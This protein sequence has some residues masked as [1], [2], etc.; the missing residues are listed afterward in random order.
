[1]EVNAEIWHCAVSPLNT[2]VYRKIHSISEYNTVDQRKGSHSVLSCGVLIAGVRTS[3]RPN[4]TIKTRGLSLSVSCVCS[5]ERSNLHLRYTH[6]YIFPLHAL[7]TFS[8]ILGSVQFMEW[9]HPPNMWFC[10]YRMCK[11]VVHYSAAAQ[12][13]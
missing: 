8:T 2:A 10:V 6:N 13:V 1:M 7:C 11:F 5:L 9:E 12:C 4:F 3:Y